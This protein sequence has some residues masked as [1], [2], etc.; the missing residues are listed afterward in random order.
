MSTIAGLLARYDIP[1]RSDAWWHA[2]VCRP[3]RR[4]V[5][6]QT[7]R[8]VQGALR[9][10]LDLSSELVWLNFRYEDYDLA[11][12]SA[13]RSPAHDLMIQLTRAVQAALLDR[14]ITAWWERSGGPRGSARLVWRDQALLDSLIPAEEPF[15]D[16]TD[17]LGPHDDL[18]AAYHREIYGMYP[19]GYR[20]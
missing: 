19:D 3:T 7:L 9:G 11:R 2:H 12:R 8:F 5:S 10:D 17:Y 6:A 13:A 16:P 1:L 20:S 18:G 4:A 15:D 14:G